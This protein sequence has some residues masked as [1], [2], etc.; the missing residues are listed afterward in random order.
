M[1]S[2][3]WRLGLPASDMLRLR[4]FVAAGLASTDP[5]NVAGGSVIPRD[6]LI[7]T[8]ARQPGGEADPDAKERLR[9]HVVGTAGGGRVEI[10]ADLPMAQHEEWGTDSGTYSTGVPPSI[11]AQ[12]LARGEALRTGVGGAEST[13]PVATFFAELARRGMHA[14]ITE[15]RPLG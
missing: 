6:V 15:R 2:V 9:A 11:A 13:I 5:V 10:D 4:S 8:L 3:E 14:E 12:I 7:A 1:R